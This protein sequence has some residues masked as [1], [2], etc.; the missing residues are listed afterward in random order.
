VGEDVGAAIS[1]GPSATR[2]LEKLHFDRQRVGSLPAGS[3]QVFDL[4]GKLRVNK[5]C[6]CIPQYGAVW[7][8]NHRADLRAEFLRLATINDRDAGIPGQ[9]AKIHWN[10]SVVDVDVEEGRLVLD[11]GEEVIADLV[12]GT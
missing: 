10:T 1:V 12:I 8:F 3:T 11:T 7:L 2:I 5:E 6:N 9:L 4:E